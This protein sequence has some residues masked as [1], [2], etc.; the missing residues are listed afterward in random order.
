M[1]FKG[2]INI[3]ILKK[4]IISLSTLNYNEDTSFTGDG[5]AFVLDGATG[6]NGKNLID[7]ESDA[8][9]YVKQWE[10]FLKDNITNW[11][12]ELKDIIK[13]GINLIKGKFFS[14]I[15]STEKEYLRS[16]DL[17]SSTIA[18]VR[19]DSQ[20]LEYFLLGDCTIILKFDNENINYIKDDALDILDGEV[21]KF[22][23]RE[24][25]KNSISHLEARERA[26]DLLIRNRSLKNKLNGYWVLGFSTEAAENAK[27]G[28]I[29]L[30]IENNILLMSDGFSVLFEKYK[31]TARE[32]IID[33]VD[34]EG[35]SYCY[36]RI[37]DVEINDPECIEYPRLK[38]SDD[39]SAVFIKGRCIYQ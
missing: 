24:M 2:G 30:G 34:G 7:K 27:V 6:L 36:K 9:W 22:M 32:E 4:E 1:L 5:F 26:I 17:P 12:I 23:A 31:A 25:K 18:L 11:D 19:W 20:V 35:V 13:D 3:K 10:I 14:N 15:D 39:S 21:I 28:K 33:I 29:Q 37:R 16:I 38:Q 8:R